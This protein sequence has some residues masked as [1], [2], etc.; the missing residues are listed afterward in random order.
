MQET[1][2]PVELVIGDD[3]S[4]DKTRE[5]C[6]E[7]QRKFP[8][9]I[10]VLARE[11]NLGIAENFID[12][13][14][15]CDGKYIALCEG[16]D[17]WTHPQKLQK[18]TDF[19]EAN[20]DFAMCFHNAIVIYDNKNKA[21]HKL[22]NEKKDVFTFADVVKKNFSMATNSCVYRNNIY[23][24]LPDSFP[25]FDWTLHLLVSSH[26]NIKF[27]DEVMS[28][29]RRHEGGW[30]NLSSTVKAKRV[31]DTT[32]RCKHYF[33][34]ANAEDFDKVL[35]STYADICFGYFKDGDS[36][37]F[38]KGYDDCE[39]YWHLMSPRKQNALRIRKIFFR[40]PLLAKY[41]SLF[42]NKIGEFV[43]MHTKR[44]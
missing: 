38:L 23:Q 27:F 19:L 39:K 11:K 36:E 28:I 18:Q 21:S 17:Y 15:N 41:Y 33:A 4:T 1:D 42:S 26:G 14:D 37:N 7:Y 30:T 20:P 25:M 31:L 34:P 35:A 10:R 13:L 6:L 5:I 22:T 3:Y 2:F 44:I 8:D 12:A 32:K 9:K 16:D 43:F 24:S 29:Y 40:Y